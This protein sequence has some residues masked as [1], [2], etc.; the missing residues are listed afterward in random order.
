MDMIYVL[1]FSVLLYLCFGTI[2]DVVFAAKPSTNLLRI[3]TRVVFYIYIAPL[4]LS[5]LILLN[6][7]ID[8]TFA[9]L[10][11]GLV[12]FLGW[13]LRLFFYERKYLTAVYVTNDT[14]TIHYL[15]LLLKAQSKQFYLAQVSHM[16]V[17]EANWLIAYPA[18]INI[19]YNKEL[20]EFQILG[21]ALKAQLQTDIQAAN[22]GFVG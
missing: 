3:K 20:F 9:N 22:L 15:T 4:M 14:L 10:F 2:I 19:V 13:F 12:I 16:D 11:Y 7:P 1:L 6:P 8:N 5:S 17:T 18:A 21:K